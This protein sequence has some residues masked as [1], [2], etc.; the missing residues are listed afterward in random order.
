LFALTLTFKIE[1][2][3][4]EGSLPVTVWFLSVTFHERKIYRNL[5]VLLI[6]RMEREGGRMI[7]S[8]RFAFK[9]WSSTH[10]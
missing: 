2:R 3:G 1:R 5:R 9:H 7:E 8:R 4:D 10:S 6:L